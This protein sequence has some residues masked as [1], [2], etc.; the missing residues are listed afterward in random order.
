MDSENSQTNGQVVSIA[1]SSTSL[2]IE[3]LIE[4]LCTMFET[5][6]VRRNRLYF[7]NLSTIL[8]EIKFH[9]LHLILHSVFFVKL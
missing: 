6:T 5:D 4:Q 8:I 7:G 9:I 2:L 3:S 1:A